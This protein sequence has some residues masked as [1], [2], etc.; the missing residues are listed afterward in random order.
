[1]GIDRAKVGRALTVLDRIGL[2][3]VGLGAGLLATA[4]VVGMVLSARDVLGAGTVE[5]W[6]LPLVGEATPAYAEELPA[7]VDAT[8]GDA[9]VVVDGAP[10]LARWL[11]WGAEAAGSRAAI[12][13][14]LALVWLCIRVG[15]HRPFGRSLTV[16]LLT[17]AC[18]VVFGGTFPPLFAA[19]ARAEVIDHIGLVEWAVEAGQR[20]VLTFW[21]E[22]DL[23][24]V[25]VG[26]ALG[27][28]AAAFQIGERLQRD[29]E[30]LV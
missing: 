1:M 24:P 15:R 21:L 18:L 20:T 7:V 10:A 30:G 12:G 2:W 4:L 28:V 14:C 11:L 27:V 22:I 6:G 8:Y 23:A 19:M 13:I 26:L 9:T 17:T 3:V 29:T 16:A 25:G 5:V